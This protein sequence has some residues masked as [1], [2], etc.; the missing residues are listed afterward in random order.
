MKEI[1]AVLPEKL[2]QIIQKYEQKI[3]EIRIRENQ[4]IMLRI[5]GKMVCVSNYIADI[6]EIRLILNKAMGFSLHYYINELKNGFIT[7]KNGHRIGVCGEGIV[8][9]DEVVNFKKISSINI[10]VA[11]DKI[12]MDNSI[13]D[14]IYGNILVI[15]PPNY[16]KTTFLRQLCYD[17]A[18][19]NYNLAV[20]D[21]RF[22]INPIFYKNI[23][24]LRGVKKVQG[25]MIMLRSMSP[26]YIILDE[27][28]EETEILSKIS[29]CGVK[30][31]AS[32]HAKN[33]DDIIKNKKHVLKH[34]DTVIEIV[35]VENK[36]KYIQK[37]VKDYV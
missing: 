19:K 9:N 34:F 18:E 1:K 30:I 25:T 5:D 14:E 29:N 15:S 32:I 20:I 36:R 27:I 37:K 17:L 6:E 33:L 13:F 31:V 35:L 4:Q 11:R 8:E 16:G 7:M 22:E 3:E 28:T 26:D 21:E 12:L 24:I 23:D 10:R 2:W